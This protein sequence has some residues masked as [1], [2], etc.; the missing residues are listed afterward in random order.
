MTE[1]DIPL[2]PQVLEG[3]R[4]AGR[5]LVTAF[6]H[7]GVGVMESVG[8]APGQ[9]AV[10]L[11]IPDHGSL[12]DASGGDA[13]LVPDAAARLQRLM[14]DSGIDAR[15]MVV[16]WGPGVALK[17]AVASPR[18]AHL[19]SQLVMENL[20]AVHQA[21]LRLRNTF[22]AA[23]ISKNEIR[24]EA[25]VVRLGDVSVEDAVA[26]YRT[27]SGEEDPIQD[28]DLDDWRTLDVLAVLVQKT[29]SAAAGAD[30]TAEPK[31]AC[32]T[33]IAARPHRITLGSLHVEHAQCLADL[34]AASVQAG[35]CPAPPSS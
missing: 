16:E 6:R 12:L 29:V 19:L 1:A 17:V 15:V 21:A 11:T 2:G 34:L 33:C 25:G 28:V 35:T 13:A 30:V 8:T 10:T 9:P 23:Q 18:A 5:E 32:A 20:S 26:L 7:S 24:A 27:L 22:E 4:A 3:R 31:P 14:T